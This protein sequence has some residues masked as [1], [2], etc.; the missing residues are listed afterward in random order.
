[1]NE[2]NLREGLNQI[3]EEREDRVQQK[4][5]RL[6]AIDAQI[7]SVDK[8][9]SGLMR[10]F[11]GD[12]DETVVATLK[13]RVNTMKR[14]KAELFAQREVVITELSQTTLSQPQID[15]ILTFAAE[16][17]RKMDGATHENKLELI[18]LLNVR[19]QLVRDGDEHRVEMSCD[20]PDSDYAEV[21]HRKKT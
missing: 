11:E 4:R 1:M 9:I 3:A 16:V 20:I 10:A 21:T 7:K 5:S 15:S 6:D 17:R 2:D 12:E 19:V 18:K 8:K 13:E 14:T